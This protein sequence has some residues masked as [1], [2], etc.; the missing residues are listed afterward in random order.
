MKTLHTT[1][2]LGCAAVLAA[3]AATPALAMPQS[4][5]AGVNGNVGNSQMASHTAG[6]NGNVG[7]SQMARHTAGVNG[8]VG[9]SQMTSHS[10][11]LNALDRPQVPDHMGR[12]GG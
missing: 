9:N 10:A 5:M 2:T 7:N 6:V 11:G 4:M 8:T 12:P 3:L 1:L